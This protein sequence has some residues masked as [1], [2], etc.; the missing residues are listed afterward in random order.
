MHKSLQFNRK[1]KYFASKYVSI[2]VF[3]PSYVTVN[4]GAEIKS[5]TI[6]NECLGCIKNKSQCGQV[7][8]IDENILVNASLNSFKLLIYFYC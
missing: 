6:K 8:I 4:N 7:G 2:Q 5:L 3:M 1:N